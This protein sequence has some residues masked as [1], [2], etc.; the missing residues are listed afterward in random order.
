MGAGPAGLIPAVRL[1]SPRM[2]GAFREASCHARRPRPERA[3]AGPRPG[4]VRC[5]PGLPPQ[6]VAS[7]SCGPAVLVAGAWGPGT[8]A[9]ETRPC[10]LHPGRPACC[11][12]PPC[13]PPRG[14]AALRPAPGTPPP[15]SP[16]PHVCSFPVARAPGL[17]S[18]WS[19][20]SRPVGLRTSRSMS[21]CV[22]PG[23]WG[24]VW[25]C[26]RA[27]NHSSRDSGVV[28][29]P[30]LRAQHAPETGNR[31]TASHHDGPDRALGRGSERRVAQP[32]VAV[33]PGSAP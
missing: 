4:L 28:W 26:R 27:P 33:R 6:P 18:H 30:P 13:R 22:L 23:A 1:P 12:E 29:V 5:R 14:A 8:S 16:R 9:P 32:W 7:T 15:C 17:C 25:T 2:W 21:F 31:R 24:R 20:V 11:P 10:S 19:R 3:A